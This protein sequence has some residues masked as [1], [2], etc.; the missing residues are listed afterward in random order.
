MP[1]T[2]TAQEA[3]KRALRDGK[4]P[5]DFRGSPLLSAAQRIGFYV[6]ESA[7]LYVL[8]IVPCWRQRAMPPTRPMFLMGVLGQASALTAIYGIVV[9]AILGLLFGI[10]Y[11]YWHFAL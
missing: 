9:L 6:R 8:K 3:E 5:L 10:D 11:A 1:M 7:K 4:E 2:G